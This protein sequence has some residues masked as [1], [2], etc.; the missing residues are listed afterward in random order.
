MRP[1]RNLEISTEQ[2]LSVTTFSTPI[3]VVY[4]HVGSVD[5]KNAQNEGGVCLR[6]QLGED[7]A[8]RA[9]YSTLV[10]IRQSL[11][12]ATGNNATDIEGASR[13][14]LYTG[15]RHVDRG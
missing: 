4:L 10:L 11:L 7:T 14:T 8:A 5:L 12:R 2:T 13:P 3:L 6:K 9:I 1:F 15:L